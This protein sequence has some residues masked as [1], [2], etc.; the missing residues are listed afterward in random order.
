MHLLCCKWPKW[1]LINFIHLNYGFRLSRFSLDTYCKGFI[2]FGIFSSDLIENPFWN[3]KNI[4]TTCR[5]LFHR[6]YPIETPDKKKPNV[7]WRAFWTYSIVINP[8]FMTSN[9]FYVTGKHVVILT[10]TFEWYLLYLKSRFGITESR[11]CILKVSFE[12]DLM[13]KWN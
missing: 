1:P 2:T 9:D 3:A 11:S 13:F 6:K 5:N 12:M 4:L 7:S 8:D 10:S